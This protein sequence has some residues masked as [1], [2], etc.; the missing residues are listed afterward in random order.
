MDA[1]CSDGRKAPIPPPV[2][3]H[4]VLPSASAA[5]RRVLSVCLSTRWRSELTRLWTR[6]WMLANF[7]RLFIWLNRCIARSRLANGRWLVSAPSVAARG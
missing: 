7:C 5:E 2:L 4:E 6:A 3:G 1:N